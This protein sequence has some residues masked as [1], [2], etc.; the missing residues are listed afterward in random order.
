MFNP[1]RQ[2]QANLG[3][4][5]VLSLASYVED[6]YNQPTAKGKFASVF[7][8]PEDPNDTQLR[9]YN[10]VTTIEKYSL[11]VT[12]GSR[13]AILGKLSFGIGGV[14]VEADFDWKVGTQ[15]S[16]AASFLRVSAAY[17]E[18]GSTI[19]PP[20]VRIGAMISSGSRA[21]RSQVTRT[22]PQ[23]L[24]DTDHTVLFPIPAY[25]HALNLF[26]DDQDFYDPDEVTVRYVGGANLGISAASTCLQSFK[27]DAV[28]FLNGLA[29]EDG[30]RFPEAAKWVELSS[31][32]AYNVTPCFT[33]SF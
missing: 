27:S 1:T 15:L 30:V 17:S 29:S 19:S 12:S 25:A 7:D 4:S 18:V 20:E 9:I 14:T 21:A 10:L 23:L 2:S 13:L 11:P 24:V 6:Q 31:T 26:A 32:N 22:Y 28:P 8:S 16:L 33:L 5:I 3:N